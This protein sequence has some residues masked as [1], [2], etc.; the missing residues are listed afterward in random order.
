M[1]DLIP[2]PGPPAPAEAAPPPHPWRDDPPLSPDV[3][4]D[5]DRYGILP[6]KDPP[7]PCTRIEMLRALRKEPWVPGVFLPGSPSPVR[8]ESAPELLPEY[9]RVLVR[10]A[11]R[12][13]VIL[14]ALTC[15]AAV[16]TSLY[17]EEEG[18]RTLPGLLTVFF[19]AFLLLSLH[20]LHAARRVQADGFPRARLARRHW[21]WVRAQPAVF[22]WTL[23][24]TLAIVALLTIDTD[25]AVRGAGLVKPAVWEGEV[26]RMLTGPMLHGGINHAWMNLSALLVLGRMLEAH[27]SRF[28]LPLA[29]LAAVVGGSVLSL[30]LSPRPSVGASGGVMGLVGFL[31]MLSHLRPAELP[32]DFGGRM[33][34]VVGATAVLGIVGLEFIDNWAHLGGLLAGAGMGRLLL[35]GR[36]GER[37][38]KT[39]E[40]EGDGVMAAVGA[41]AMVVL[42]MAMVAA[43][44]GTW[45][46]PAPREPVP[47]PDARPGG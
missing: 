29:F 28:H 21:T 30:L 27:T 24:V 1:T 13:V 14:G 20:G 32:D 39:G 16:W 42:L 12:G 38:G 19:T 7:R 10:H 11:L 34:Y 22:T 46:A 41:L 6:E 15:G 36:A 47:Y 17:W 33:K 26:W 5:G 8:P 25:A 43:V 3:R 37:G 35:R 23:V 45:A 44:A 31:W 40:D 2:D 18:I 4:L 9:R